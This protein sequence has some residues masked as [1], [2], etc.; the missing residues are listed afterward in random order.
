MCINRWQLAL[1]QIKKGKND[2]FLPFCVDP[3]FLEGRPGSGEF[4]AR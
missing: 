3:L 1:K 4:V 2:M